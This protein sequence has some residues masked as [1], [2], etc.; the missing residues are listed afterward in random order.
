MAKLKC[1]RAQVV[2]EVLLFNLEYRYTVLLREMQ[3]WLI[4][5]LKSAHRSPKL[6]FLEKISVN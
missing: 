3:H 2:E 4:H 6:G 1:F 5:T